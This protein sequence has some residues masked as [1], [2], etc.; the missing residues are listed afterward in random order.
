VA[1]VG[2]LER[3]TDAG[4]GLAFALSG[5]LSLLIGLLFVTIEYRRSREITEF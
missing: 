2:T 3:R 5:L 1:V 4:D